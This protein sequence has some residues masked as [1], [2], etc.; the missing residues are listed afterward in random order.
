ME[1]VVSGS[2]PCV[3]CSD[4]VNADVWDEELGF[5]L[6]CSNLYW[7]HKLDPFTLELIE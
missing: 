1:R 2:K 6:P 4:P 7:E 3:R 5:C